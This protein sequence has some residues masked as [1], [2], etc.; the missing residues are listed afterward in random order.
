MQQVDEAQSKKDFVKAKTLLASI[1][2]MIK[3]GPPVK[4]GEP[5]I[6]RPED[7]YIIQR[8]ALLTYKSKHPTEEAALKEAKD[9]LTVLN[10]A[11]S[12]DTETLGL[13][14]SVHKRL[15]DLTKV[16][17]Y[18]DEA[19]R[20][21]ERGFYLRNDYYNGI[22]LAYLLNVRCANTG[23]PAEAIADFVQA[24]RVRREVLEICRKFLDTEKPTGDVQY[25]VKATEAEACFGIGDDVQGQQILAEAMSLPVADWMK[26]STQEQLDKL[27]PLLADSPLKHLKN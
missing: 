3:T 19:I 13:W 22:N 17:D 26:E 11:T 9:L 18:L 8:L 20:S 12:N 5:V 10:P 25:W 6:E 16:T 2:E 21:Y 4:P 23:T 24:Q 7:P 1:R 27:K 14:G 15:W